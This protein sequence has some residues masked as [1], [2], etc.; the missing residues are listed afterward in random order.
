[1]TAGGCR[2]KLGSGALG[3]EGRQPGLDSRARRSGSG[4]PPVTLAHR[5]KTF[6]RHSIVAF[7]YSWTAVGHALT[8]FS[9]A[10]TAFSHALRV[11]ND[12]QSLVFEGP[13]V[14]YG[15]RSSVQD[16]S[17]YTQE[18]GIGGRVCD[19]ERCEWRGSIRR[20]ASDSHRARGGRFLT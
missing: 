3:C 14:G 20:L 10:L 16:S 12:P 1:M 9:R 18:R 11:E 8:P 15:Q 7:V 6:L 13:R 17:F 19:A 5:G 2:T 4:S